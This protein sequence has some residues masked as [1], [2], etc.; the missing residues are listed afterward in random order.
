MIV[1]HVEV[2][3][4]FGTDRPLV[5]DFY[6]DVNITTGQNGSGKTTLL[7]LVWYVISGNVEHALT[8]IDFQRVHIRTSLYSVT[9]TKVASHTCKADLVV[10]ERSYHY[11]DIVDDEDD[12]VMDA[13]HALNEKIIQFGQSLFFPTFRR[14]EG[15][16]TIP[17]RKIRRNNA[18]FNVARQKGELQDA[19]LEISRRLS[20][21][22]HT[23]VTSIST[24]DV[25]EL[26]LR[27][28][29]EMSEEASA[30]QERMS[31]D[32]V[33]RIKHFKREAS[34]DGGDEQP[35]EDAE[36]VLDRIRA[37]IEETDQLRESIMAPLR[38]VQELGARFFQ[39]EGIEIDSRISFGDAA[40]AINSD[41]L[42]AGEKQMLS[43]ICYNAFIQDSVIFIDEP[44]LSL[45][46]D[47]QRQL[48][49]TLMSQG[50]NNQFIVAT[51]SPFIYG[52]Y[53]ER[54]L[55]LSASRGDSMEPKGLLL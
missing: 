54:E 15:G 3:G 37:L 35:S 2:T 5:F 53:P 49:P 21:G 39:H 8:E 31:Q 22:Q 50:K 26:L 12:M 27:R 34:Q 44:E 9:V 18:L 47:W 42:S 52:K 13:R 10:G 41:A 17:A 55:Q 25:A 14:I 38:A 43:F 16:F 48:F 40:N 11:E 23:F 46:V 6:P 29:S 1:E 20:N 4:L 19:V 36:T 7:K 33:D 24:L 32:V 30:A 45:H 51:H 28:Y